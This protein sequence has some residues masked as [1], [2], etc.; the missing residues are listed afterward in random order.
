MEDLE[1]Y[2]DYTE[3]EDDIPK[4]KNA[5]ILF[6]KIAIAVVCVIVVGLLAFRIIMFNYYPESMKTIYYNDVLTEYYNSNSGDI[7]AKTQSLR[8][9]YDDEKATIFLADKLIVIEGVKQ[10][11]ITLRY[12]KALDDDICA[13]YGISEVTPDTFSFALFK[14]NPNYD[15]EAKVDEY[16]PI[17]LPTGDAE[18][19]LTDS[20]L[21]Y[22]YF[23]IVVDNVDLENSAWLSLAIYI[24]GAEK[25][26]NP[27]R[28]AVYE[29][30]E[31]HNMFY[32]YE[33]S[34]KELLV[35]G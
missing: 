27:R 5:F 15:S 21:S 22:N 24:N 13:E 25:G 17:F 9:P 34:G 29:N 18:L 6:I 32:D 23:R 31:E 11:Q 28:V 8:A 12:N 16:N 33:L 35:N 1:R 14:N 2:G 26:E 3:Y 30:N 19:V 20:S 4:K 10:L 7:G